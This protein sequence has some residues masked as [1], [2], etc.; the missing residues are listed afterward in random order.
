M[1]L[2]TKHPEYI[3]VYGSLRR[4]AKHDVLSKV[5][6]HLQYVGSGNFSGML[7]DLGEYPGAIESH[8]DDST[9]VKGEVYVVEDHRNDVFRTLDKYEGFNRESISKSLFV[10]KRTAIRLKNG[11]TILGWIYLYNKPKRIQRAKQISSGDYIRFKKQKNTH[12]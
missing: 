8:D 4:D 5:K 2:K 3:F 9:Q 1:K 7:F 10:R 12:A 6:T 11:K